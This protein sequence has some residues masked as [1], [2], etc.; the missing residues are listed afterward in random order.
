[1]IRRPSDLDG[2]IRR[3][4]VNL[5]G[6]LLHLLRAL[7]PV[8]GGHDL[9]VVHTALVL[10]YVDSQSPSQSQ[11]QREEQSPRQWVGADGTGLGADGKRRWT[12]KG[13]TTAKFMR[14]SRRAG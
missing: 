2:L 5:G 9:L 7:L 3:T 6:H 8:H 11:S 13:R 4:R 10:L 12:V 1:M 14:E